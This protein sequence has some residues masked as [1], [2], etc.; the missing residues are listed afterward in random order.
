MSACFA[1][2]ASDTTPSSLRIAARFNTETRRSR[3]ALSKAETCHDQQ[4][5]MKLTAYHEGTTGYWTTIDK[6]LNTNP[7]TLGQRWSAQQQ[8]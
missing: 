8:E 2:I 1:F 5:D 3:G 6:D 7:E 4:R